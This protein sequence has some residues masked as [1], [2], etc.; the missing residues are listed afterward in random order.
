MG[1]VGPERIGE[2]AVMEARAAAKVMY[3]ER[4]LE[5]GR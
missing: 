1:I 3:V 2:A 4:M 5:V